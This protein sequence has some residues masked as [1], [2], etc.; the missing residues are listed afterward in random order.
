MSTKNADRH[1]DEG[2]V[3]L[4]Q[5]GG[6]ALLTLARSYG[7]QRAHMDHVSAVGNTS[8]AYSR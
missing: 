1:H 5:N 2:A 8:R 4:E 3:R 6:I 7:S